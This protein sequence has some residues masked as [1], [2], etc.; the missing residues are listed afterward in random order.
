MT[1]TPATAPPTTANPY[2]GLRPFP[3]G[4]RLYGR[5]RELRDLTG[6][7]IAERIV[8]MHSP[9]GAGKTS[10]I[11]A[12]LVPALERRAFRVEPVIR[13]NTEPPD[14]PPGANRYVLSALLA[15]AQHTDAAD[16]PIDQLATQSLSDYLDALDAADGAEPVDRLLIFD[17]FEEILTVDP[18]SHDAKVAFFEQLGTALGDRDKHRWALFSMREDYLAGLTPYLP[19]VP[20]RFKTTF[21]LDLLD[22]IGAQQAIQKPVEAAGH[23]FTDAAAEALVN[24]LRR[25]QVQRADDTIVKELGQVIEPV[26]LQVVC[27]RL[28]QRLSPAASPNGAPPHV[29]IA[30]GD[31]AGVDT[32]DQLLEE[33]YA[34]GVKRTATESGV[35][36]RDVREWFERKLITSRGIRSQV[37][38][39]VEQSDGL[40]NDVIKVL[41]NT[42]LVRAEERSLRTWYE[43][44]HDRLIAPVRADNQRWFTKNLSPLQVQAELWLQGG[45]AESLLFRDADLVAAEQWVTDYAGVLRPAEQDF[46]DKCK[47][48][49]ADLERQR[50]T[51]RRIRQLAIFSSIAAVV[52][53]IGLIG[54]LI[55]YQRATAAEAE[56]RAQEQLAVAAKEEALAQERLAEEQR[57]LATARSHAAYALAQIDV[58]PERALI[59]ARSATRTPGPD[60]APLPETLEV[61]LRTQAA[62][63]VRRTVAYD[64]ERFA[65]TYSPDGMLLA[66]GGLGRTV[67]LIDLTT[68]V[69][70]TLATTEASIR[71]LAFSRDGTRL[72]AAANAAGALVWDVAS[73]DLVQTVQPG[74]F[75]FSVAFGADAETLAVA[76]IVFDDGPPGGVAL[77]DLRTGATNLA[78]EHGRGGSAVAMSNDGSLLVSGGDDAM[79]RVTAT[80]D[81]ELLYEATVLDPPD[82]VAISPDNALVAL[83]ETAAAETVIW[84]LETG[85]LT[86]LSGHTGAVH[87][88]TFSADGRFLA[89]SAEDRTVRIY[90]RDTLAPVLTLSGF[91]GSVW[92]LGFH[93]DGTRLATASSDGTVQEWAVA[94]AFGR[95]L[96]Y[97][98]ADP[99]GQ[100]L[101]VGDLLGVVRLVDLRTDALLAELNAGANRIR[102]IAFSPDGGT[103]AI[104]GDDAELT[105]WDV[106]SRQLRE[107]IET[108]SV[109]YSVRFSPDGAQLFAAVGSEVYVWEAAN[110]GE[111]LV[112]DLGVNLSGMDLSPDGSL[113]AVSSENGDLIILDP[114]TGDELSYTADLPHLGPVSFSPDGARLVARTLDGAIVVYATTAFTELE[115][116]GDALVIEQVDGFTFAADSRRMVV[117]RRDNS[118]QIIDLTTA[119][120]SLLV[121]EPAPPRW[122]LFHPDQTMVISVGSDGRLRTYPVAVEDLLARAD[123]QITRAPTAEE[124]VRF[125]LSATAGCSGP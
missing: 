16:T 92:Q 115:F 98:A 113:L 53:L 42:Y 83:V 7:I 121:A 66:S 33:W 18:L 120:T 20:T 108:P 112:Y 47:E 86:R 12:A 118:V 5:D 84:E 109:I 1:P 40:A 35:P 88:V 99:A 79:V 74:G 37:L 10:L 49:R 63:P 97:A 65:V 51:A 76:H 6:L 36:E 9:S 21:R 38:R 56:A 46:L 22:P 28:W 111:P 3:P 107:T 15:L 2:V 101:A 104:G 125:V 45:Q 11:Q 78:V 41:L 75:T 31:I 54:A 67:D 69:T 89:T 110:S 85:T 91:A 124:C 122:A 93:P 117:A 100:V 52:A 82:A 102:T 14:A 103:L 105:L 68:G 34:E 58:N 95:E 44:A 25:V 73:G 72:A 116:S 62:S 119:A 43:L 123:A 57:S 106:A 114:A 70:R 27:F 90:A 32:V 17:Q 87:Q 61:L 19:Y 50:R 55:A 80:A 39:G 24:D 77:V 29:T 71:Q 4:E 23:I 48:L 64:D 26:Q 94:G 96:V 30:P 8:L 59:L 81:G 60:G 13:V